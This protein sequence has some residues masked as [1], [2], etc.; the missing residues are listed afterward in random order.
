MWAD[1]GRVSRHYWYV[2]Y[3]ICKTRIT[4]N[5]I[6]K[7]NNGL[8]TSYK[9]QNPHGAL[10]LIASPILKHNLK[11]LAEEKQRIEEVLKKREEKKYYKQGYD[12]GKRNIYTLIA[13]NDDMANIHPNEVMENVRPGFA[14]TL[15][16]KL[17]WSKNVVDG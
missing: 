13:R 4:S 8:V 1:Y 17:H 14:D 6:P 2:Q 10:A 16:C 11:K 9:C 12:A 15:T 5:K 7:D 3:L